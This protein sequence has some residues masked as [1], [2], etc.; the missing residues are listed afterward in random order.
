MQLAHLLPMVG[1][2]NHYCILCVDSAA[3]RLMHVKDQHK[4]KLPESSRMQQIFEAWD[5]TLTEVCD[6]VFSA[7]L[8]AADGLASSLK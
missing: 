6:S 1:D 8:F 7:V 3:E 5:S 2:N 4:I